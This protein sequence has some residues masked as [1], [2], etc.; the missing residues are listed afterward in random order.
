MR[1]F[2]G[3]AIPPEATAALAAMVHDLPQLAEVK[4]TPPE[5]LHITTAFIGEWPESRLPEVTAALAR[6]RTA[7]TIDARLRG[8]GWMPSPRHPRALYAGVESTPELQALAT[9]TARVLGTVGVK[10][11][12]RLYRPHVTLARVKGRL[13]G[14]IPVHAEPIVSFTAT[15]FYLYLSADGKYTKLEEFPLLQT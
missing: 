2:A 13:T 3:L 14:A 8:L 7:S 9:E 1:L 6:V 15:S 4:W 11:E 5:K 12:D 10:L